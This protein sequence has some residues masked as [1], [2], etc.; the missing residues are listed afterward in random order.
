VSEDGPGW[1]AFLVDDPDG[2]E[3]PSVAIVCPPC[4]AEGLRYESRVRYT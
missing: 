4:A 1:V 2:I 3:E